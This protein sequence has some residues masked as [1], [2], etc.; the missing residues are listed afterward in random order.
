MGTWT[1][2]SQHQT[3]GAVGTSGEGRTIGTIIIEQA[4]TG[5]NHD[6]QHI[7]WIPPDGAK[8]VTLSAIADGRMFESI[9]LAFKVLDE[10]SRKLAKQGCT[11]SVSP[12]S[13]DFVR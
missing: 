4:R 6:V 10:I 1:R 3:T 8:P 11:A 5:S 13:V 2:S 9:S 12:P 7:R